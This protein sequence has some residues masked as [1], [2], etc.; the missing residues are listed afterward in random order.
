M[1]TC[2]QE[3][4]VSLLLKHLV[5]HPVM[6]PFVIILLATLVLSLGGLTVML[7]AGVQLAVAFFYAKAV[8]HVGILLAL[9]WG[10]GSVA[11][12]LRKERRG[13]RG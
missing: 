11:L 9:S 3:E 12:D 2:I 13:R 1:P 8:I 4:T 6:G 10:V 5:R 7:V